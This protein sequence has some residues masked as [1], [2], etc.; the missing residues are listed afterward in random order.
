MRESNSLKFEL[1]CSFK[2]MMR[3]R[4][5]DDSDDDSTN[6]NN[7]LTE[8]NQEPVVSF[9]ELP[10]E[11][12]DKVDGTIENDDCIVIGGDTEG[13]KNYESTAEV[14]LEACQ[15]Y[16][17]PFTYSNTFPDDKS[18]TDSQDS[19]LFIFDSIAIHFHVDVFVRQFIIH[20]FCPFTV[21]LSPNMTAQYLLPRNARSIMS[22]YFLPMSIW[23]MVILY[24]LMNKYAPPSEVAHFDGTLWYP[25]MFF[26]LH[27]ILVGTKYASLSRGEY[28]R[29]M[30]SPDAQTARLYNS[31]LELLFAWRDER[32]ALLLDFEIISSALRTGAHMDILKFV[33]PQPTANEFSDSQVCNWKAFLLGK[34]TI[35]HIDECAELTIGEDGTTTMSFLAVCRAVMSYADRIHKST[36]VANMAAYIL[37]LILTSIPFFGFVD[38]RS[39]SKV[40]TA[41]WLTAYLVFLSVNT[42]IWCSFMWRFILLSMQDVYRHGAISETMHSLIRLSDVHARIQLELRGSS[43]GEDSHDVRRMGELALTQLSSTRSQS[44]REKLPSATKE[45]HGRSLDLYDD[46]GVEY[47]EA[48]RVDEVS[49]RSRKE[50]STLATSVGD[51]GSTASF[52]L[53][54]GDH[55]EGR[56]HRASTLR[57]TVVGEHF[58][59]C[60]DEAIETVLPRLSFKHEEN[61]IS[62][63]W[64]RLVLLNVGVRFTVRLEI[65]T[66]VCL[67]ANMVLMVI[68]LVLIFIQPNGQVSTKR[69]Y[70]NEFDM[71]TRFNLVLMTF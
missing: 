45:Q 61:I 55:G 59:D 43:S 71:L 32:K 27:R 54:R 11:S 21:F 17:T 49:L 41:S 34:S 20:A 67:A 19:Q 63:S 42:F 50:F 40:L 48:L 24:V 18:I 33:G 47:D 35:R 38:Y 9:W 1:L 13:H 16:D 29:F 52:H 60:D 46:D 6:T 5:D 15:Q 26:S 56:E 23:A 62:W 12:G 3:R 69:L 28:R 44:N 22:S 7:H 31:Q 65:F 2:G 25:L 64:A 30:E 36:W 53:S 57:G 68:A 39:A 10:G 4:N 66:G 70:A 14:P 8:H 58:I 51:G 37:S